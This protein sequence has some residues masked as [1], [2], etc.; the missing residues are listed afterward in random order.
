MKGNRRASIDSEK[1]RKQG[2]IAINKK[3]EH[4]YD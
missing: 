2:V 1:L 4:R 3:S